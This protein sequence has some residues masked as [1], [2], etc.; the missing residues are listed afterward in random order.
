MYSHTVE[1]ANRRHNFSLQACRLNSKSNF[2]YMYEYIN[3]NESKWE[4][5]IPREYNSTQEKNKARASI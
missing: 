3:Q 4:F 2:Q 1:D 5:L